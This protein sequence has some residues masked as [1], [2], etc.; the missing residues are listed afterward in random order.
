MHDEKES[1]IL[2]ARIDERLTRVQDDLKSIKAKLES[3]LDSV[4]EDLKNQTSA[5]NADIKVHS[6]EIT[7]NTMRYKTVLSLLIT[8][9]ISGGGYAI[10]KIF[11]DGG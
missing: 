11:E 1:S 8:L 6:E 10:K 4:N 9:V 5:I 2:L 7:K 3:G